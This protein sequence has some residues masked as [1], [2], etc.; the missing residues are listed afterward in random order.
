MNIRKYRKNIGLSQIELSK[1]L[2]IDQTAIS[3]WETGKS[4]PKADK[5]PLLA[6]VLGCTVDELF[7]ENGK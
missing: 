2:N 1:L 6:S 5:L 7:D 4:M 3:M